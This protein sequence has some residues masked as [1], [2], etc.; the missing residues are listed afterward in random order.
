MV[1]MLVA[2]TVWRSEL[3]SV[4]N[5]VELSGVQLGGK[6]VG[7]SGEL[8]VDPLAETMVVL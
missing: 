6:M 5:W 7:G 1:V 8:L 3:W 4:E 2:E